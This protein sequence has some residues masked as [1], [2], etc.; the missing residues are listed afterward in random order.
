MMIRSILNTKRTN[1]RETAAAIIYIA[2]PLKPGFL[3][4]CPSG[5]IAHSLIIFDPSLCK[6]YRT[7]GNPKPC[8]Y[9]MSKKPKKI[10]A[11]QK[12]KGSGSWTH[13]TTTKTSEANK[14]TRQATIKGVG[15]NWQGNCLASRLAL[16]ATCSHVVS[17]Q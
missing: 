7:D 15:N 6:R 12:Q 16:Q 11:K 4:H 2:R 5:R 3:S 1:L 17:Q 8:P 14:T 10:N 9:T 13:E